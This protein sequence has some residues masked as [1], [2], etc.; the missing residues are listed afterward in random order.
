VRSQIAKGSHHSAP[1]SVW[2]KKEKICATVVIIILSILPS[3]LSSWNA[4]MLLPISA[5]LLPLLLLLML[6]LL[7][8]LSMGKS[9]AVNSVVL[10]KTG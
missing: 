8:L 6:M 10:A 5:L 9:V 4:S 7:L 2:A 3:R 1:Q